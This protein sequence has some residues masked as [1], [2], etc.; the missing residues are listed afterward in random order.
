MGNLSWLA[1]QERY[2]I[3]D[4]QRSS[5]DHNNYSKENPTEDYQAYATP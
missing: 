1:T 3:R 2:A 4:R 5:N